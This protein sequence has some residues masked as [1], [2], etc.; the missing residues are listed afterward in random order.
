M[1]SLGL[2]GC[3]SLDDNEAFE[4][5]VGRHQSTIFYLFLMTSHYFWSLVLLLFMLL[6]KLFQKV[7][8][9]ELL[10]YGLSTSLMLSLVPFL[11]MHTFV[12]KI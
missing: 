9:Q 5:L 10:D 4:E 8:V 12:W 2:L 3:A 6:L 11:L 7:Q 1:R